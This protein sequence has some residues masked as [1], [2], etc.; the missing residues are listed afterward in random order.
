MTR[1]LFSLTLLTCLLPCHRLEAQD[2]GTEGKQPYIVETFVY[3]SLENHEIRADVYRKPGGEIRPGIIWIHGGALIFGTRKGIPEEQLGLYLNAGFTVI[4]IDY[5]LAPETKLPQII[6]DLE[7]AHSWV[8]AKG[9]GLFN[10]DPARIGIIGHSAGGY[11]T[12]MAGF[13]A[14]PTP[15][16]L[17]SFYGYGDITGPWYSA[18]DSFYNLQPKIDKDI[19]YRAVGDSVV[20]SAPWQSSTYSRGQFYLYC[21]QNGLWPLEVSGHDPQEEPS[22]FQ[23]Y[24]P[25]QNV[26]STYPPTVLLHGESDTD[27]PFWQSVRMAEKL[28]M[29]G[30]S[31]E[32]LTRPD[33]P[34]GFDRNWD[35]PYVQE[36]FEKILSF[37]EAH[38]K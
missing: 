34:H 22:W 5:R 13:R 30:I 17:V 31:Y 19:A 1:Y 14:R 6:S 16:A 20:S 10:V 25:L 38:L 28:E 35:D 3:K 15:R 7:D 23:P 29:L 11:L 32:L 26:T 21:R 33:W 8:V 9:P 37:L 12:L 27:V 24:E 4:A 2:T 36:A 18:P